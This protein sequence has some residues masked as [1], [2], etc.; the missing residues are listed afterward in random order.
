MAENEERLM[1]GQH[2]EE[3]IDKAFFPPAN[4]S[5]RK[6]PEKASFENVETDGVGGA[7]GTSTKFDSACQ[8]LN[9]LFPAHPQ[10]RKLPGPPSLRGLS[11]RRPKP[12]AQH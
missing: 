12:S 1:T 8:A 4:G 10:F 3:V 5:L 2:A 9:F 7:D 6:T 11:R